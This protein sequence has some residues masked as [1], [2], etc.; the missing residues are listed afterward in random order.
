MATLAVS[1]TCSSMDEARTSGSWQRHRMQQGSSP[2]APAW[3]PSNVTATHVRIMQSARMAGTA[4]FVTVLALAIGGEHAS[5]VSW[6]MQ[7]WT[8]ADVL[9]QKWM[10]PWDFPVPML[11]FPMQSSSPDTRKALISDCF[12]P[13]AFHELTFVL[14]YS[15]NQK[16]FTLVSGVTL[17]TVCLLRQ[18]MLPYVRNLRKITW[19]V[20]QV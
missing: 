8:C 20:Y 6:I 12:L 7:S 10:F 17:S 14:L 13:L 19:K 11:I 15:L 18:K 3:V 1:E 4:S 5:E 16:S 2:P 9:E